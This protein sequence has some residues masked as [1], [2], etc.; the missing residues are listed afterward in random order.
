MAEKGLSLTYSGATA[1]KFLPN[2]ATIWLQ[3]RQTISRATQ[4]SPGQEKPDLGLLGGEEVQL[5]DPATLLSAC[6]GFPG[7]VYSFAKWRI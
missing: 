6:P 1:P 5:G 3:A 4:G 7:G 2:M